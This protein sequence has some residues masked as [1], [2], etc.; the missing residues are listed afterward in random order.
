LQQPSYSSNY[1]FGYTGNAAVNGYSWDMTTPVLGVTVQDGLD[2]SGVIYTYTPV[3]NVVDDFTVTVQ[4]ENVDGGY[5]FQDTEDW[6]G[7]HPIRI[8][9]VL[10]LAYTPVSQFGKGSIETTGTGSVEDAIVL[11]M[12]RLDACYDPQNDPSCPGYVEPIP[13]IPD[14]EIYDA[15][16]DEFVVQATEDTDSDLYDEKEEESKE[17]EKDEEDKERLEIAMAATENALTIANTASQGV[18]L[19]VMNTATNINSYYVAQVPGGVYKESISL[20]GGK[21]VDNRKALRSLGQDNLMDA[22]I[23]EQYK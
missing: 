13:K 12:Y 4:S 11:Y 7:K 9:K 15:L 10:P 22:M 21:I 2:I 5:I 1:T 20:N 18:L 16:E 8:K 17:T 6:S 23:Q 3:K 19:K 14:I